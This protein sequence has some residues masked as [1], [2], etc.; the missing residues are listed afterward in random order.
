MG[1]GRDDYVTCVNC[2]RAIPRHKAVLI[3]KPVFYDPDDKKKGK[4]ELNPYRMMVTRRT[5]WCI[6]CAKHYRLLG[7]RTRT[8]DRNQRRFPRL[9]KPVASSST[10]KPTETQNKENQ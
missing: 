8:D 10:D 9:P 4:R 2:G 3:E 6:S 7:K 1:R 5:F